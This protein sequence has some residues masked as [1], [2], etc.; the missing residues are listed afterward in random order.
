MKMTMAKLLAA[1][2]LVLVAVWAGGAV[3]AAPEGR[4][5][6]GKV[7]TAAGARATTTPRTGWCASAGRGPTW[8]SG[9]TGCR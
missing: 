4:P 2:V 8:P 1:G 7:G 5:D 9:W 3:T 6:A